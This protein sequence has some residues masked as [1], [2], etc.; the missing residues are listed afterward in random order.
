MFREI[1]L[2][3]YARPL[4]DR[5]EAR[6]VVGPYRWSPSEPG[7]GRGFYQSSRGLSCDP[8]GS[9]FDLRL[10]EANDLLP[11]YNRAQD[12]L[13]Y[14]CDQDG[15]GDTLKPIVARLPKGRGFLPGWTM[16]N[17][18]CAAL[19]T[20]WILDDPEDAARAAHEVAR[21]DANRSREAAE[22]EAA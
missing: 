20:D 2:I 6:K 10:E 15:E 18:M 8:R 1:T 13:G 21:I 5:S 3:N 7:K 11:S 12:T 9:T 22:V 19:D 17:G 16:G 4:A 14:Y